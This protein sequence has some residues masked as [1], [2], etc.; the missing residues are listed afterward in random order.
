ML[1][2]GYAGDP[3]PALVISRHDLNI[4]SVIRYDSFFKFP[5]LNLNAVISSDSFMF[6]F[7][8]ATRG[9]PLLWS[10]NAFRSHV[11]GGGGGYVTVPRDLEFC[12]NVGHPC[13]TSP[14]EAEV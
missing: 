3:L 7:K 1:L 10:G 13:D 8:V 5:Y 2:I 9:H 4:Q 14:N 11:L 12:T 6:E